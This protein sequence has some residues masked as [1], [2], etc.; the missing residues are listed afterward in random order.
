[1]AVYPETYTRVQ[2]AMRGAGDRVG[3]EA[4]LAR[5]VA[6][7]A[8]DPDSFHAVRALWQPVPPQDTATGEKQQPDKLF[9][10]RTPSTTCSAF[11]L[12]SIRRI[13]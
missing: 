9:S 1:M 10:S 13:I 4:V 2:R 7:R 6:R 11:I 5:A 12:L 3:A 8:V